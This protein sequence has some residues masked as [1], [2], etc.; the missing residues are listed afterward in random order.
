MAN[1]FAINTRNIPRQMMRKEEVLQT[2]IYTMMTGSQ[3]PKECSITA[4]F[5]PGVIDATERS[6]AKEQTAASGDPSCLQVLAILLELETFWLTAHPFQVD[7]SPSQNWGTV[8]RQL[9]CLYNQHVD[10]ISKRS[11]AS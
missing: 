2:G 3:H 1:E 6:A 8:S 4:D 10:T 5:K 7:T 11:R 9:P